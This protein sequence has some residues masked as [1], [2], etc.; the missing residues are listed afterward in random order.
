MHRSNPYVGLAQPWQAQQRFVPPSPTLARRHKEYSHNPF[1]GTFRHAPSLDA[2][3][4]RDKSGIIDVRGM[5]S[6]LVDDDNFVE[7][8]ASEATGKPQ[9]RRAGS[10]STRHFVPHELERLGEK[11]LWGKLRQ[12]LREHEHEHEREHRHG[13]AHG[14]G[15]GA[16]CAIC[17]DDYG[18]LDEVRVLPCGHV[19][20][21][22]CCDPWFLGSRC[23]PTCF[24]KVCPVCKGG[25]SEGQ[26]AVPCARS[27]PGGP[28]VAAGRRVSAPAASASASASLAG[29]GAAAQMRPTRPRARSEAELAGDGRGPG[30]ENAGARRGGGTK[31]HARCIPRKSFLAVGKAL[32]SAAA[33]STG[34]AA[35]QPA[36]AAVRHPPRVRAQ[37]AP[38]TNV[39]VPATG[40][41]AGAGTGAGAGAMPLSRATRATSPPQR[42]LGH[43]CPGPLTRVRSSYE[44]SRERNGFA[45]VMMLAAVAANEEQ[46][47]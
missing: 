20:H 28:G 29:G 32:A 47:A 27:T 22:R 30:G 26:A 4:V 5:L 35:A 43:S 2:D 46:E 31:R 41:S 44:L 40:E 34:A 38:A 42:R 10:F 17:L 18:A 15:R 16:A 8:A 1:V 21:T 45:F 9:L 13:H 6:G 19:F 37:S 24:T 12:R 33:G 7:K 39:P 14:H 25:L 3:S 11:M 36:A 23:R